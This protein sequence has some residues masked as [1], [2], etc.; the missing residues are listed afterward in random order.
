MEKSCKSLYWF[1]LKYLYRDLKLTLGI[2]SPEPMHSK[3]I[4]SP[5]CKEMF[6]EIKVMFGRSESDS[7]ELF[8]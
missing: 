4:F 5:S 3:V 6:P 1:E 2:G 8:Y 7:K